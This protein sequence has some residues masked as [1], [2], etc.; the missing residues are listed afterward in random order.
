MNGLTIFDID[1]TLFKTK[2]LINVNCNGW[3]VRRLDNQE[4]NTYELGP[5]ESYDFCEF[6]S[7]EVFNKTS[8]PI[9]RMIAKLNAIVKNA[10]KVGS[11]VIIVTARADFDDKKLFLETFREQGID[12]DSIYVERA[13]NVGGESS[14]ENKRVIIKRYLDEGTYSRT[15]LYDDA[16]S[17]LDMFLDLANEYPEIDFEAHFV[18]HEGTTRRY[19]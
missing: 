7:A 12:I 6:R 19:R 15:R 2:A 9:N 4:F 1:E 8:E 14:A 5:G 11:K 16:T 17:N 3:L 13:G 10:K 18:T